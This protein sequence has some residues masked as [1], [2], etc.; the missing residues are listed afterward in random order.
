MPPAFMRAVSRHF[1]LSTGLGAD[2]WHP[3]LLG[4]LSDEALLSLDDLYRGVERAG[5]WPSFW[6]TIR[7]VFPA[8]P[9]GGWRPI[10]LYCT[11]YRFWAKL[12][13]RSAGVS[14]SAI[15]TSNHGQ[16]V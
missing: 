12:R 7:V 9:D 5:C 4:I 15:R 8:K 13:L 10:L 3:R 2:L 11:M 14:G 16:V 6:L 1:K